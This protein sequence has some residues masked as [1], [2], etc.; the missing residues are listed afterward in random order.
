M[1]L[2]WFLRFYCNN[3]RRE[4]EFASSVSVPNI[5]IACIECL[6]NNYLERVIQKLLLF[7]AE[8][9]KTFQ[10]NLNEREEGCDIKL[11]VVLLHEI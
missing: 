9:L 4:F 10:V 5:C 6:N 11:V 2:S 7:Q 1:S 3:L 8:E